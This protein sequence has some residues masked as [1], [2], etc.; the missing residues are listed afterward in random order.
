MLLTRQYRLDRMFQI[1]RI[2]GKIA[3][4]TMDA[5]CN[6][7]HGERYCQVFVNK[8]LF[9]EAY[10]INKKSDC[11]EP[12]DTFIRKYGAPD[13]MIYDG[14]KEQNGNNTDFQRI[15]NKYDITTKTSEK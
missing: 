15:I 13:C 11:H 12:L 4:D 2:R 9:V 8:D 14:S 10:T 5:Q 6:L 1:N 7:I 3:T